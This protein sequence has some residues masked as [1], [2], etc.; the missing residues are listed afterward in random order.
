[1][2]DQ[3]PSVTTPDRPLAGLKTIYY[4]NLESRQFFRQNGPTGGI[5]LECWVRG[6]EFVHNL[7]TAD[8]GSTAQLAAWI[9]ERQL[10]AI[11]REEYESHFFQLCRELDEKRRRKNEERQRVYEETKSPTQP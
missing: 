11:T 5:F 9:L 8:H 6:K 1:M 2:A 7:S 4:G 3:L 10:V